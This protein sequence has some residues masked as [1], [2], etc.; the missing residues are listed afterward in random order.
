MGELAHAELKSLAADT[1]V[2]RADYLDAH[3]SR[4]ANP[5]SVEAVDQIQAYVGYL[6]YRANV[7]THMQ[8][9]DVWFFPNDYAAAEALFGGNEFDHKLESVL[10]QVA[11]KVL[12]NV[13]QK[14]LSAENQA[15]RTPESQAEREYLAVPYAERKFARSAGAL[16]DDDQK[17]WYKGPK[18]NHEELARYAIKASAGH[19]MTP[20]QE[21][22]ELLKS[23]G[24]IVTDEPIMNGTT[25]R[26][27]VAGDKGSEK[28]GF[29]VGHLDGRPSG[30]VKNNR[31][32][33]ESKWSQKGYV[34]TEEKKAELKEI[35]AQKSKERQEERT[36]QAMEARMKAEKLI[37]EK[38]MPALKETTPDAPYL[39]KKGLW[40]TLGTY[41][42]DDKKLIVPAIDKDG[43][44]Q[45]YQHINSYGT[46]LF[47]AG[48]QKTG[49][50]HVIDSDI[51]AGIKA[52]ETASA[53]IIAEGYSTAASVQKS[54]VSS[55]DVRKLAVVA[56]IDS[57]NLLPVAKVLREK[58]PD[59][60]ML[61]AGDDDKHLLTNPQVRKNVGKD[62]AYEAAKA[63]G[64]AVA[65]PVFAEGEQDK[66][67][68][69]FTDFNDMLTKSSLGKAGVKKA[70][71]IG[72]SKAFAMKKSTEQSQNHE[73]S[74]E[75]QQTK[76]RS[77][78][79]SL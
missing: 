65:L 51:S 38:F 40:P 36:K 37:T 58:F 67:P 16:W 33:E 79:R 73:Q 31:T 72:V 14:K 75:Q 2:Y 21:F 19:K 34:L 60:P 3:K 43:K 12:D 5:Y 25:Q 69:Q 8:S 57:G 17:A 26:I 15:D 32:G 13:E 9:T 28:S 50:F 56:A 30:Y 29:Y 55:E 46:K 77:Q 49:N 71:E 44:L 18:A 61:I 59:K 20:Q 48:G 6:K 63:V 45:T 22:A 35:A 10:K 66:N 62:K 70:V 78:G 42:D 7:F 4:A 54:L 53:I 11:P 41:V 68:K 74:H 23:A 64:A 39:E 27:A 1:K 24:C 47:M 76:V 52:L